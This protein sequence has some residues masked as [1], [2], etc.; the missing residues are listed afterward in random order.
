MDNKFVLNDT[1]TKLANEEKEITIV[2]TSEKVIGKTTLA[3]I[4]AALAN[5]RVTLKQEQDAVV[6]LE[7]QEA[8]AKKLFK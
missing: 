2:E 5:H 7:K 3:E 4:Q 8:E 1:D 6:D